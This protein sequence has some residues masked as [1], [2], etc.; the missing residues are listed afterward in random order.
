MPDLELGG[1]ATP[2]IGLAPASRIP[3]PLHIPLTEFSP[4][5]IYHPFSLISHPF[6]F[7][8][9]SLFSV[10]PFVPYTT[11]SFPFE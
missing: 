4:L 5:L 6:P 2:R 8:H 1:S 10:S 7:T 3:A 9:S 11:F